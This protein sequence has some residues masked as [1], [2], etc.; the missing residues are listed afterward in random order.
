MGTALTWTQFLILLCLQHLTLTWCSIKGGRRAGSRRRTRALSKRPRPNWSGRTREARARGDGAGLLRGPALPRADWEDSGLRLEPAGSCEEQSLWGRTTGLLR[1][2]E[3][4]GFRKRRAR[5][6]I[7][8]LWVTR[9]QRPGAQLRVA[10]CGN[11][12]CTAGSLRPTSTDDVLTSRDLDRSRL[13][14]DGTRM[15]GPLVRLA[16]ASGA[17]GDEPRSGGCRAP[18]RGL[19]GRSADRR[20]GLGRPGCSRPCPGASRLR[21]ALLRG[22]GF[23]TKGRAPASPPAPLPSCPAWASRVRARAASARGEKDEHL[24]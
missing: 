1:L 13:G 10:G 16:A 19:C 9:E 20:K 11:G 5:A 21:R 8:S 18:H 6:V 24:E 17:G 2:S 23:R 22:L 14:Y 12:R 3:V 15:H 7:T 4:A